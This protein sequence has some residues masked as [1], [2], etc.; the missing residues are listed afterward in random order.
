MIDA[1]QDHGWAHGWAF[2]KSDDANALLPTQNANKSDLEGFT[3]GF[4]AALADDQQYT[5]AKTIKQAFELRI[6]D[7][8]VIAALLRAAHAVRGGDDWLRWPDMAVE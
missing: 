2:Y 7:T 4:C 3:S 1:A 8:S 5:T 6:T